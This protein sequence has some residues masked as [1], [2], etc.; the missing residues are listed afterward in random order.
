[1]QYDQAVGM[2]MSVCL[3]VCERKALVGAYGHNSV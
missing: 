3:S 2:I 1:M